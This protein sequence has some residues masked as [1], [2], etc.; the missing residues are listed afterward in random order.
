MAKDRFLTHI[1]GI[2][3]EIFSMDDAPGALDVVTEA[4]INYEPMTAFKKVTPEAFQHFAGLLLPKADSEQLTIV[5]RDPESGDIIGAMISEDIGNPPP[6]GLDTLDERFGP[7][8]TLLEQLGNTYFETKPEPK[9]GEYAHLFMVG[10]RHTRKSRGVG[11][12]LVN[13]AVENAR[14]RGYRIAF[15]ETTGVISQHVF[16]NHIGFQQRHEIFYNDFDYEG[17]KVFAKIEGHPSCMLVD[18]EL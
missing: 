3:Y 9:P 5:A 13:L 16:K 12:N 4:F 1:N 7:I 10:T 2:D 14:N 17:E 8:F 15:A 11:I 18:L 6:E